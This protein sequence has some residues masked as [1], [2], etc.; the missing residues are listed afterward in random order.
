MNPSR[1]SMPL[2]ASDQALLGAA[3]STGGVVAAGASLFAVRSEQPAAAKARTKIAAKYRIN[4][5]HAKIRAAICRIFSIRS[6]ALA[7]A[8][9]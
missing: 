3:C 1:R 6:K 8:L 9:S 5:L 2:T 4:N 7:L